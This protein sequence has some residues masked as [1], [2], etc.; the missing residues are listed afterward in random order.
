M[1]HET[2]NCLPATAITPP[3]TSSAAATCIFFLRVPPLN[4]SGSLV[5]FFCAPLLVQP[6]RALPC[7]LCMYLLLATRSQKSSEQEYTDVGQVQRL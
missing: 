2:K 1:E 6:Q 5:L 4:F 3:V 7:K